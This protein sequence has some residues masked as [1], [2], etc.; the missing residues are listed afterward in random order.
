MRSLTQL[1]ASI[2]QAWPAVEGAVSEVEELTI[3]VSAQDWHAMALYLR[4]HMGFEQLID[5]CAVDYAAYGQ[6]N[7]ATDSAVNAGFSRGVF[8]FEVTSSASEAEAS[9]QPRFAVVSHLLSIAHNQRIRVKVF[10][11]DNQFPVVDSVCDVWASVNWFEREAFD[12]FGIAFNGHPDLRRLLTDYGFVGY[13]LRKDFPL[14]GH[15]EMRY[16][17]EQNRVIYEPV[18][19]DNRVNTPRVIRPTDRMELV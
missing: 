7:W 11:E 10:C 15:V 6:V 14:E 9:H 19:I 3:S 2:Q 17:P 1:L 12:L 8:D 5:L 16:D 13:P 4:D 18:S